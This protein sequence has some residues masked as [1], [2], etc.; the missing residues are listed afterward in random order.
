M[1]KLLLPSIMLLFFS[2]ASNEDPSK[3]N[4]LVSFDL[5]VGPEPCAE[6]WQLVSMTGNIATMA[7]QVGGEMAWQEWYILHQDQ[8][9]I[10]VRLRDSILTQAVGLYDTLSL[11][12]DFKYIEFV[13][14]ADNELIGNCSGDPKEWLQILNGGLSAT[15]NVCDGPG[16]FYEKTQ[17]DCNE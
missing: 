2:C 15:W 1:K 3:E 5:R 12:G 4:D 7:P 17:F 11:K 10:K 6:R 16:L 8:T 13:Y 9:F 14:D